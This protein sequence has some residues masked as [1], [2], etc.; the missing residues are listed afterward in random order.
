[1]EVFNQMI[2]MGEYLGS[3]TAPEQE[4]EK[5]P[6]DEEPDNGVAM[7]EGERVHGIGLDFK[8]L[9]KIFIPCYYGTIISGG[10]FPLVVRYF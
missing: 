1:M 5:K 9:D 3:R 6:Q 4:P 10:C 2:P 7:V 8:A